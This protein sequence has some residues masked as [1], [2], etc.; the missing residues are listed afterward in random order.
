MAIELYSLAWRAQ[1]PFLRHGSLAWAA[2][3][4]GL[5]LAV[6][7]T[8]LGVAA[9][10]LSQQAAAP[11]LVAPV[12]RPTRPAARALPLPQYG[13]RFELT[14]DAIAAAV[15][16]G[17]APMK[18]SF[19]YQSVPEA[20]LLRQTATFATQ[21]RWGELAP[22]LD[23]MQ[24][25]HRAAYISRLRLSREQVGQPVVEAEVQLAIAYVLAPT[26]EAK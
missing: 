12:A 6:Q 25:V 16:G 3:G 26:P 14:R 15:G 8:R 22:L 13:Q 11:V 19:A 18:I 21:T 4:L 17:S 10:Q 5:L 2:L 7:A 20:R 23:R 1:R 24:E 9:L